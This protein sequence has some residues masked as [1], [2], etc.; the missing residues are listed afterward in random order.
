M[1][2]C[3]ESRDKTKDYTKVHDAE[4][5]KNEKYERGLEGR[6]EREER[7]EGAVSQVLIACASLQKAECECRR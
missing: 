7:K 5:K 4:K 2:D 1:I 6:G 3:V